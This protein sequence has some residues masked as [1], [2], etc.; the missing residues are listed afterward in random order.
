MACFNPVPAFRT[1]AGDVVMVERGS[2]RST[3]SLACGRCIGCRIER[4]RQWSIRVMHEASLYGDRNCFLTLTYSDESLPSDGSLQYRRDFQP[5]MRRL[6]K[7]FT[8]RKVRFFMCGEYGEDKARPHYH[9]ALF[10]CDFSEDRYVFKDFGSGHIVFRS[11][12]LERLWHFGTSCIGT[13]TVESADYVARYT[14]KKVYGDL[15]DEHYKTVDV[16]TG[17]VTWRSEEF[18]HMSLKPGI[19]HGWFA[20]F[21]RE[22]YPHD[23]VVYKGVASKPPRYYDKLFKKLDL[24]SLQL[25]KESREREARKR[26]P[27]NTSER[28]VVREKV[29]QARVNLKKRRI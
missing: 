13:L 20:K 24:D 7:A 25:M 19:G 12:T 22:V 29:L 17:E 1:D 16:N 18:C 15:A 23:R 11:P 27:D 28:L 26:W 4:A 21:N 2:I 14:L 8:D 6:R 9:V 3:M 10:N 5:F